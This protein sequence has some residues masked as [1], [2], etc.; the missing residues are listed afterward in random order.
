[1]K[2][3]IMATVAI[4]MISGLSWA[5]D[6]TPENRS[7]E[8]D[9]YLAT[10]PPKG[11]FQDLADK[12]AMNL[13]VERRQEFKD[14]LTKHLDIQALEKAIKGA[15]VKHFTADEL[16][17]LADFYSSPAGKSAM[18]KFGAYMAEVMPTIQAEAIK[19]QAKANREKK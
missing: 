7:M 3:I 1:M 17:A 16:K 14:L 9:R 12:L 6:D 13:P 8:A 18:K 4:V 10:T 11:M 2:K 5:L 15:L 19:A